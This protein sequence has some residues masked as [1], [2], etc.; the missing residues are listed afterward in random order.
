MPLHL[1]LF[2][3]RIPNIFWGRFLNEVVLESTLLGGSWVVISRGISPLISLK[4][5]VA[6]LI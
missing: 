4:F 5:I 6:Q 3:F 2:G 1:V